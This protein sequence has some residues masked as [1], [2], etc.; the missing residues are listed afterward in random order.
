[1]EKCQ[2]DHDDENKE[3]STSDNSFNSGREPGDD[4]DPDYDPSRDH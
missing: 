1:L 2:L 4:S 3:I